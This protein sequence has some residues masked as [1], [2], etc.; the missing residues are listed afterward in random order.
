MKKNLEQRNINVSVRSGSQVRIMRK[1]ESPQGRIKL[2]YVRHGSV[3]PPRRT[4]IDYGEKA[5]PQ[6]R[7]IT[8]Q[9]SLVIQRKPVTTTYDRNYKCQHNPTSTPTTG[10]VTDINTI[11]LT[12]AW[13]TDN[14]Y[15]ISMRNTALTPQTNGIAIMI[16][17]NNPV[18]NITSYSEWLKY[19]SPDSNSV[20]PLGRIGEQGLFDLGVAVDNNSVS[21]SPSQIDSLSSNFN[22]SALPN[23]SESTQP[24]VRCP[25]SVAIS[26][27]GSGTL[28]LTGSN[29]NSVSLRQ[30]S[31]NE[32][33]TKPHIRNE[34]VCI[35]SRPPLPR[36][37][38]GRGKKSGIAVVRISSVNSPAALHNL[39]P[40]TPTDFS[41][42]QSHPEL[43]HPS[44]SYDNLLCNSVRRYSLTDGNSELPKPRYLGVFTN[45]APNSA[46]RSFHSSCDHYVNAMPNAQSMG[47]E[48]IKNQLFSTSSIG[49]FYYD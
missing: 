9:N 48:D 26:F 10:L 2:S 45:T 24:I 36:F 46:Q 34:N 17:G 27:G 14:Q 20:S 18:S 15:E 6:I 25:V 13:P 21:L 37:D 1:S 30:K 47:V 12:N 44:S 35:S 43:L 8:R 4:G 40:K 38:P 28:L 11:R 33:I 39:R 19:D 42:V 32:Q 5:A 31:N 22:F 7:C 49:E 29:C 16:G 23:L 41:S 3:S